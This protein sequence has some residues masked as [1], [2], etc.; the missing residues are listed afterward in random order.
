MQ[1]LHSEKHKKS[2]IPIYFWYLS[3]LGALVIFVYAIHRRDPVFFLG[4]TIAILIY[5]RNIQLIKK[6]EKNEPPI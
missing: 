2:V 1:W 6:K 5:L 3:V 4:Q